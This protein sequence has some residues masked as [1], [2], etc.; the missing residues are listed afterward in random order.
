MGVRV[1]DQ[2]LAGVDG[3]IGKG[4]NSKLSVPETY[5]KAARRHHMR[6][7]GVLRHPSRREAEQTPLIQSTAV[8]HMSLPQSM[9]VG[10]LLRYFHLG[11]SR[12]V[13]RM[14]LIQSRGV[15][16]HCLAVASR[17]GGQQ[18][19]VAVHRRREEEQQQRVAV[20]HRQAGELHHK[21]QLLAFH[22]Q[23]KTLRPGATWPCSQC[24]SSRPMEE[25]QT[26][27]RRCM[28]TH[29]TCKTCPRER[30]GCRTCKCC[31]APP[32]V[33]HNQC[34][35]L[36]LGEAMPCTLCTTSRSRQEEGPTWPSRTRCKI[37]SRMG[38]PSGKTSRSVRQQEQEK[39]KVGGMLGEAQLLRRRLQQEGGPVPI[40]RQHSEALQPRQ[41][42]RT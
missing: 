36:R 25:V 18:Q 40:P 26:T 16:R 13:G 5:Q 32:Q 35:T 9:A 4:Q 23:R 15:G 41:R 29:T 39:E 20:H 14:L 22:I 33:P 7:G 34:R 37:W 2:E 17:E 31:P 24:R 10:Q 8:A 1:H 12:G 38:S 28:A 21:Q 42:A 19:R 6:E 11:Q 27:P 3:G 30:A